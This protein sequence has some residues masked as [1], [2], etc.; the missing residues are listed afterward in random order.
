MAGHARLREARQIPVWDRHRILERLGHG[1]ETGAE[2]D[3][4]RRLGP[5]GAI[6]DDVGGGHPRN[7]GPKE[8]GSNSASVVVRRSPVAE[9]RWI[10]ASSGMNSRSRWRQPP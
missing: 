3:P 10:V 6:A 7:S 2:D 4:E 1:A 8:S 9:H 5:G